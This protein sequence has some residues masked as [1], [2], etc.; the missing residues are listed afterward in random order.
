MKFLATGVGGRG[1]WFMVIVKHPSYER[2][3]FDSPQSPHA[4][5][6]YSHCWRVHTHVQK[7]R[8]DPGGPPAG[9]IAPSRDRLQALHRRRCAPSRDMSRQLGTR[10]CP[11]RPGGYQSGTCRRARRLPSQTEQE[12]ADLQPA[13]WRRVVFQWRITS[14]VRIQAT[15][16]FQFGDVVASATLEC[17]GAGVLGRGRGECPEKG[18]TTRDI[19]QHDFHHMLRPAS[20]PAGYRAQI[21]VVR[22][23]RS[24]HCA[25]AAPSSSIMHGYTY[26]GYLRYV[27]RLPWSARCRDLSPIENVRDEIG[28]QLQAAA[29]T[30]GVEGRLLAEVSESAATE[31]PLAVRL[32][33]AVVWRQVSDRPSFSPPR[34]LEYAALDYYVCLVSVTSRCSWPR[35]E[36]CRGSGGFQP[37]ENVCLG[38]RASGIGAEA[39][40]P[41]SCYV[42][43]QP[44]CI[45]LTLT[46][47]T[48]TI[49]ELDYLD[50]D[51]MSPPCTSAIGLEACRADTAVVRVKDACGNLQ[52]T[53]VLLDTG[54]QASFSSEECVKRLGFQ[55]WSH[56]QLVVYACQSFR[57][58]KVQ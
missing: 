21:A 42:T 15:D 43:R 28:R 35:P 13:G 2:G 26:L 7:S 37:S 52:R 22:G 6:L 40:R 41:P 1:N 36:Y 25:T 11:P 19:V 46:P 29:T 44:C 56:A 4:W 20:G 54:S 38:P 30:A 57:P 12:R 55:R 53:C 23:E 10:L 45:T 8:V 33:V 5:G 9:M 50:L 48:T 14:H 47:T 27:N 31:R 24:S 16:E 32:R 51:P 49:P 3:R 18:P 58:I 39:A 34:A 17:C